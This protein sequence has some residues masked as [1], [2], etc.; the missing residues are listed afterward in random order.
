MSSF[1]VLSLLNHHTVE[2]HNICINICKHDAETFVSLAYIALQ[3]MEPFGL[4]I[5]D[6]KTG[7]GMMH[8][9]CQRSVTV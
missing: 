5:V 4:S 1:D 9:T 2:S 3:Y 7:S 8:E 6:L